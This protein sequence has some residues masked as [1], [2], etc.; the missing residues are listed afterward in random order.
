M[1]RGRH[2]RTQQRS[3]DFSVHPLVP[4]GVAHAMVQGTGTSLVRIALIIAALGALLLW[5]ASMAHGDD[6]PHPLHSSA[7]LVEDC[8]DF[9]DLPTIPGPPQAMAPHVS[10]HHEPAMRAI[11]ALWTEYRGPQPPLRGT[12]SDWIFVPFDGCTGSDTGDFDLCNPSRDEAVR[13]TRSIAIGF[14]PAASIV[15]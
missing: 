5:A 12:G 3:A 14:Q 4:H 8:Q 10:W 15:P 2:C 7:L 13:S 1:H 9:T 11:P 6:P